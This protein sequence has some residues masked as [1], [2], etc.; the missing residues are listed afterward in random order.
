M[1]IIA[2]EIRMEPGTREQFFEAVAPMVEATLLE[3]GCRA[4]AFTPDPNDD[5]LIRLWELWDDEDALAGHFASAHMAEWRVRGRDLPV[6]G[7]D[8]VKYTISGVEPLA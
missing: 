4:Y 1:L 8:L 6:T 2:G 5:T 3:P 7:R